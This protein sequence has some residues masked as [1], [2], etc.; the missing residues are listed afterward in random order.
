[1]AAQAKRAEQPLS[2]LFLDLDNFKTIND[3]YGH[4]IGDRVLQEIGRLLNSQVPAAGDR[5]IGRSSDLAARYGGEEFAILLP[6]THLEGALI[7]A[8]QLRLRVAALAAQPE[9]QREAGA[10]LTIT[11]SIG[12]ACFPAQADNPTDL[13][14][15]ADQALYAAK[16]AGKN[17]VVLYDPGQPAAPRQ[18][19]RLR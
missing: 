11:C 19:N 6:D 10:T 17:R 3:S 9:W 2:L 18:G 12:I 7:L 1:M 4:G 14:N 8:E 13:V 15:A 16:G 5:P